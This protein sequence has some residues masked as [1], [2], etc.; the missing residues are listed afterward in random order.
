MNGDGE[1]AARITSIQNT[2]AFAKAGVMIRESLDPDAAE[3]ILDVKPDGGIEFMARASDGAAMTFIGGGFVAP[4]PVSLKVTRVAATVESRFTAFVY[5]PATAAWRQIGW[6][7]IDITPAA[8][9]GL[10]VT[11][12]DAAVLNQS[13]FDQIRIVRN[14]ID[15]GGFEGYAPP[16]LG[17]PGWVS[18]NPLRLVPA[19]SETNQPR[20]GAKNGACWATTDEDCGMYQEVTSPAES[21][22]ILTLYA[23]ADRPGGLVG[24]NVNGATVASMPVAVHGFGNYGAACSMTFSANA[25][26][27]IRV[28]AY[29]PGTPGYVVVDDVT[30]IQSSGLP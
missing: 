21:H 7:V 5:D 18:D 30:L 1:I 25:G 6:T 10:A 9:V 16:A 29:S 15:E 4:F 17:A 20:N 8:L 28:W 23:N 14:L 27:T 24:V 19:K 22:Y 26:D 13:V 11:S 3:V 12:H 2:N